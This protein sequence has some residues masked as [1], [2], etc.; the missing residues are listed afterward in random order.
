[1]NRAPSLDRERFGFER[2][3]DFTSEDEITLKLMCGEMRGAILGSPPKIRAADID[4][5]MINAAKINA[6]AAG[7][8]R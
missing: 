7:V 6:R 1:M 3:A 2:W 4:Q 5:V 8:K